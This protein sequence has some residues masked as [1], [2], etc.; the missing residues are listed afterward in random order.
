MWLGCGPWAV[1]SIAGR[2][3]KIAKRFMWVHHILRRRYSHLSAAI[4]PYTQHPSYSRFIEILGGPSLTAARSRSAEST[5]PSG[6]DGPPLH[7]ELTSAAA[8]VNQP[9]YAQSRVP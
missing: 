9:G 8:M 6:W 5:T 7:G 3:A 1:K 4:G 2:T